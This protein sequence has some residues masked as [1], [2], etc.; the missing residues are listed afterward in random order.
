MLV[1]GLCGDVIGG[2]RAARAEIERRAE[3]RRMLKAKHS[4]IPA[5]LASCD[6]EQLVCAWQPLVQAV[7]GARVR[8]RDVRNEAIGAI[9]RGVQ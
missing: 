4:V 8:R 2:A 9:S 7:K 1:E 3:E 6:G 5:V